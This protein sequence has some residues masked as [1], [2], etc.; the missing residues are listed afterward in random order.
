MRI[1]IPGGS[2]QLGTVLARHFH[3]QGNDVTV[4]S[5]TPILHAPWSVV[6]GMASLQAR[7]QKRS[8]A[9]TSASTSQDAASC[10]AT[11]QPIAQ[12]STTP[13]LTRPRVLNQVIR[14]LNMPP[15][16]WLNASTATIYRHALDRGMDEATGDLGGNEPGAPDTWNFSIKVAKDWED[17][18]FAQA[19]TRTR[20][21]AMRS[22][23]TF[24]PDR[25][26]VFDVLSTLVRRGLGGANGA[27]DQFV[28]WIHETDFLRAITWLM[29]HEE[30][31]GIVNIAAPNPLPNRDFMR[32]LQRAWG[33]PFGL[34]AT[35]WMIEVGSWFM[36]TES[37][38]V[39]KSRRVVPGRLLASGFSFV[40][41]T[42][43]E[44]AEDL[45]RRWK[46]ERS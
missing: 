33:M 8:K 14:H 41:P 37:E 24:H 3:A 42:W 17:T 9:A 16:L 39:L 23:V 26:S 29:E 11:T 28:S 22:S 21:I 15:R 36:Q 5:R 4:L 12:P 45:V 30:L 27:G 31:D 13:A 1:V 18:F 34:P 6:C 2:G 46:V 43:P 35:R 32:A 7:G 38:L 25:G 19:T 10:V 40:F 44:A 20:K